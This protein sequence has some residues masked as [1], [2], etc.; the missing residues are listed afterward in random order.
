ML[1][2]RQDVASRKELM[3]NVLV[4]YASRQGSTRE[5]AERIGAVLAAKG[6]SVD[7][8]PLNQEHELGRYDAIVLGSAVYD[9]SWAPEATDFIRHKSGMVANRPVWLFSAGSFGD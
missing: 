9:G 5:I 6:N 4:G 1:A 7:V 8:L 2:S 3:M